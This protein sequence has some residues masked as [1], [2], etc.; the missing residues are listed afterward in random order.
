MLRVLRRPPSN[1]PGHLSAAAE[2]DENDRC[3][4]AFPKHA[5]LTAGVFNVVCPHIVTLGFRVMFDSESFGDALSVILE[6]F[7]KLSKVIFYEVACKLDWNAMRRVRSLINN[8]GVK[9]VLERVHAK[10]T[11]ARQHVFPMRHSEGLTV[12]VHRRLRCRTPYQLSFG[13]T[14]LTCPPK[15]SWRTAWSN[16]LF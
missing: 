11:H 8:H 3:N 16:S 6:R 4:K 7:P 9:L 1:A 13:A 14:F 12:L 5:D 2:E 15:H 10:G